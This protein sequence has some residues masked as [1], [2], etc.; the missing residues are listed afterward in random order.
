MNE[1]RAIFSFFEDPRKMRKSQIF[2][3]SGQ[4]N[5]E[6]FCSSFAN[7][8]KSQ[9]LSSLEI[10]VRIVEKELKSHKSLSLKFHTSTN[11][12]N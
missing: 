10:H 2:N 5:L 9:P 4:S 3:F 6:L 12:K 1:E 7:S 8:I 11:H